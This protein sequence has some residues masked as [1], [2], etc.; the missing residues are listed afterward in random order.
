MPNSGAK[1]LNYRRRVITQKKA[2]DNDGIFCKIENFDNP[3][4]LLMMVCRV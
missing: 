1:R 3:I 4:F 2:Y